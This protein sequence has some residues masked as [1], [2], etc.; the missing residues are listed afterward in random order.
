[1][2]N[3]IEILLNEAMKHERTEYLGARPYSTKRKKPPEKAAPHQQLIATG[4]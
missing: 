4:D 3:A 1:M 2:A